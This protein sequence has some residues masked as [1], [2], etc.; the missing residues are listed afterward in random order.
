MY[1]LGELFA[2][3]AVDECHDLPVDDVNRVLRRDSKVSHR[4]WQKG[5]VDLED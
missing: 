2:A 5:I 4:F 3:V 1:A